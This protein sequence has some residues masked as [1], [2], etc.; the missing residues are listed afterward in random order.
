LERLKKE[1]DDRL[2]EECNYFQP[3]INKKS[4]VLD[5]IKADKLKKQIQYSQY[6][7]DFEDEN[8]NDDTSEEGNIV[9]D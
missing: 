6:N 4:K 8:I 9:D 3:K 5:K 7:R 1:Q 2:L